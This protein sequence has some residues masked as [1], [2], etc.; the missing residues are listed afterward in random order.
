L[1]D[2]GVY[3]KDCSECNEFS[4][5]FECK[6]LYNL[7]VKE[8]D[9]NPINCSTNAPVEYYYPKNQSYFFRCIVNCRICKNAYEY[10][11]C[12]PEYTLNDEAQCVERIEGCDL[13]DNSSNSSYFD[14]DANNNGTGY[15][16]CN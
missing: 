8:N 12:D 15:R 16:I 7:G 14:K 10:Y 5:W 2:D 11:Q 1:S 6:Y 9:K 13:Y 4:Q 3:P